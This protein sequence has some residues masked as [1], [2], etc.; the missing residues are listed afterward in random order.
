LQPWTMA[1]DR[2]SEEENEEMRIPTNLNLRQTLEG[3][4]LAFDAQAA[5]SLIA[6]IQF[7]VSGPEAGIYHLRIAAGECTFHAGPADAPALTITTPADV[8]LAISRGE[9]DDQLAFM[10]GKYQVE[11]DFDLLLRFN[12]LFAT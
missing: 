7:D 2:E 10:E 8:W 11:G 1:C 3:M 6:A 5:G 12:D 9:L 4:P